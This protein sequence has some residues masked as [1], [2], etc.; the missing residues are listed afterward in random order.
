MK[1]A[2]DS[3]LSLSLSMSL[4]PVIFLL[5]QGPKRANLEATT[6]QFSLADSVTKLISHANGRPTFVLLVSM[7]YVSA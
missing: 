6:G 7:Y 4:S 2:Q 5:M 3:P 1:A